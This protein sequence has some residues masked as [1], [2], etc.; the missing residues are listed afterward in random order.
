MLHIGQRYN[1]IVYNGS[2]NSKHKIVSTPI[3]LSLLTDPIVLTHL[4]MPIDVASVSK[5][6]TSCEFFLALK[7]TTDVV[8]K[9]SADVIDKFLSVD[10][11]GKLFYLTTIALCPA[12]LQS[13]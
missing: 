1:T 9:C 5:V 4:L 10:F 2:T 3:I 13:A 11:I 6:Y 8:G 7:Q 12:Y